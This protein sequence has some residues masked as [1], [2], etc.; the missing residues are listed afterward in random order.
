[1]TSA[2]PPSPGGSHSGDERPCA[3]ERR[4]EIPSWDPASGAVPAC[5]QSCVFVCIPL[6]PYMEGNEQ[7]RTQRF[8]LFAANWSFLFRLPHRC[9]AAGCCETCR[10]IAASRNNSLCPRDS[11]W[12]RRSSLR[13]ACYK[14]D[15]FAY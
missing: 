12:L 15:L 9:T 5:D 11:P 6:E 14:R 8:Y 13:F 10:R 3:S 1:M 2:R 7:I 4:S